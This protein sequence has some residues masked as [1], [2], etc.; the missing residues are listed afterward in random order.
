MKIRTKNTLLFLCLS[1]VPLMGMGKFAYENG[2][3]AIK[4]NLGS[5][6]QQLAHAR[7]ENAEQNFGDVY[8]TVKHWSQMSIM[9]EVFTGDMDATIQSFLIEISKENKD[10]THISV[11][12]SHGVVVASTQPEM[13]EKDFSGTESFNYTKTGKAQASDVH[14]SDISKAWEIT[15]C[16]PIKAEFEK[17]RVLGVLLAG[18]KAQTLRDTRLSAEEEK[19]GNKGNHFMLARNDGL[20][21][22]APEFEQN[23]VFKVNLIKEGLRSAL[24][25]SQ[26]HEGYLIEKNEHGVESLIGYDYARGHTDFPDLGWFGFVLSNT[27]MAFAAVERLRVITFAGGLIVAL[28]VIILS[29]LASRKLTTPLVTIAE[30]VE[31]VARG[32]FQTRVAINSK[33]EFGQVAKAFN[34]MTEDLRKTT[35]SK[36]YFESIIATANDAFV[37]MDQQ[38]VLRDWNQAA[39]RVFGWTRAQALGKSLEKTIIP[40]QYREA[41]LKGLKHFL[42]TGEGPIIG[43]TLE[44][45]AL[46]REGHE[47]P[48]EITVWST[49]TNEERQ[50]NAFIRDITE[51]KSSQKKLEA[52][53]EG[54]PDALL[55]VND[56]REIT[57]VNT[58]AE[59]MFGYNRAELLG[60]T[61]EIFLPE[62]LKSR[63]VRQCQDFSKEARTR[64]MGEGGN[65]FGMTKDGREI[66]IEISLGT[67]KTAMENII[68]VT[69]RDITERKTRENELRE[70]YKEVADKERILRQ[71]FQDLSTTYE[72]L[73]TTQNQLVQSE[74]LASVGQLAAGVAHE[75]NNPVGFI[76]SNMEILEQYIADYA[77]VLKMA[78]HLKESVEQ[79]D[80]TKAKSI[81]EEI[82]KLK[83]EINMDY[84]IG[85]TSKLLQHNRNGIDRIQKIVTDL[86]AFSREDKN[87][88][89]RVKIEEV[90]E[91]ILTIVQNEIKYKAKLEKK[92]GD[93]PIIECSPQRLGQV[94]INLIVNALHAIEGSGTI[95]IK[96][97]TQDGFVCVDVRDTGKGIPPEILNKIFDPFFTTKPTGQGTGLGLSISYEIIKKHNGR[98]T[99]QSK[100]GEGATFTVMLPINKEKGKGS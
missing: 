18:W 97:Y 60:Q 80:L 32:D 51:R 81:V 41:H 55:I 12:N 63:H 61:S 39:E 14:Y 1:L 16:F 13:L 56:K 76:S 3:Q 84:I 96:T 87:I 89:E 17:D 38:G 64:P 86:R 68:I 26:K 34:A 42:E 49:V 93:T 29:M 72:A 25:A 48:V 75:I 33:D 53:L 46:H 10:F 91:S 50:F 83:E 11:V 24:L 54:A 36:T 52:I 37:S 22:A 79:E 43:K 85:D 23:D 74:K 71:T 66:P 45:P 73:K 62:H 20:V 6:F 98:M 59:K 44:L 67:V 88:L 7:I 92:Y 78:D 28:I 40:P 100:I 15:F 4:K 21:I 5:T 70:A 31:K 58:Q 19:G 77:K 2:Q 65:L 90:I 47:F 35:V 57:L 30:A 9:Q 27:D 69:I 82:N 99:V 94:F 8:K 95:A